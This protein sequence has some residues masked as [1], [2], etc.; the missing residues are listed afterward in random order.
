MAAAD[1]ILIV[2]DDHD[3]RTLLA[4]QLTEAG[5]DVATA[6]DGPQMRARMVAR[7]PQLIILDLNLPREDGLQLCREVRGSSDVPIIM[8]TARSDAID[9]ILGLELGADDYLAKPFEPRELIA[10]MRNV[11]RRLQAV[12]KNL[13]PLE[14]R[15]AMI[16]DWEFDIAQRVLRDPQKRVVVL[17][18]AEYRL[19][20]K[21]V[22]FPNRVMGREQLIALGGVRA[23]DPLDRAVD[24]QISR[25][26]QKF[27]GEGATL[28]RTVRNEGYVLAADVVLR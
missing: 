3:I 25:L 15:A 20:M 24:I 8:L 7:T 2:D 6:A 26:R 16:N 9:R 14:A 11:L 4:E 12:P 23:E 28:I 19:L 17:S 1:H 5:F 21:L 10:R 27:G 22:E 18:G 13:A